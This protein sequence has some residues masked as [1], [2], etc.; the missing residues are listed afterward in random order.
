MALGGID[1]YLDER[2][3]A[4]LERYRE[5]G[6]VP[7]LLPLP[8]GPPAGHPEQLRPDL[9]LSRQERDLLAELSAHMAW[10]ATGGRR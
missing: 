1:L 5:L 7:P 10:N 6:Y 9:P 4:A 3:E 2:R 8:Y